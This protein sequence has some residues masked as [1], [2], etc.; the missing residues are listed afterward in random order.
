MCLAIPAKV[1]EMDDA[2]ASCRVGDSETFVK[3][4]LMLLDPPPAVGDYV[5]IHAGFAIRILDPKE[6]EESLAVLRQMAQLHTGEAN[7]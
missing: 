2:M 6:A 1:V 7:F 5:I 3:A 4:S